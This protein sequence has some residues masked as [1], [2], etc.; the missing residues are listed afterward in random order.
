MRTGFV[1]LAT[2][3]YLATFARSELQLS[4]LDRYGFIFF[5]FFVVGLAGY[6]LS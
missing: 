4:W 3:G 5:A 6:G 2:V 1:L